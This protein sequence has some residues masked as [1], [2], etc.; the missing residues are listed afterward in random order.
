[1]SEH[2]YAIGARFEHIAGSRAFTPYLIL[3]G[4]VRYYFA[5]VYPWHAEA[6]QAAQVYRDAW[7]ARD[8]R[9]RPIIVA[10]EEPAHAISD[11]F[12]M[13]RERALLDGTEG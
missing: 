6:L 9:Q 1:M 11:G 13:E 12:E 4:G 10:S 5:A 7:E 2:T 3:P 8:A